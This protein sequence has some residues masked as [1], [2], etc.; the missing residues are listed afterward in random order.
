MSES[1]S[2]P[3][4]PEN[5]SPKPKRPRSGRPNRAGVDFSAPKHQ[6]RVLA[7]Q[8]LFEF[9]QTDH[10]IDDV[11]AR[12]EQPEPTL[13]ANADAPDGAEEIEESDT[14]FVPPQVAKRAVRLTR[15]VLE[16]LADID[17][18]IAKAAP[19]YPV[20]QLAAIDRC[21]L[22]IA[23]YELVVT[24]DDV[25]F[26]VAIN[27]AVEIAKRYGGDRSGS[28]VNGVLGTIAKS[29]KS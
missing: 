13:D 12:I 24:G 17:P 9:D 3:T 1:D 18:H 16:H 23:V 19:T 26:K 25:P 8:A 14:E 21:V 4:K 10:D 20:D 27:E 28:F 15:G 11:L 5:S 7:M 29:V 2:S 22:R 6:A